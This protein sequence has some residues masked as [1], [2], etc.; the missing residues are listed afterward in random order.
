M[1]EVAKEPDMN[2]A[3][4]IPVIII[5]T[6]LAVAV[7]L[8]GVAFAAS[9]LTTT[10]NTKAVQAATSTTAEVAVY[11][12][13]NPVTGEHHY[14]TDANE[15]KVLKTNYRWT[16]EGVGWF[17]PSKG[18]PVYRLYNK[19][20]GEHL[21]TTDANE[22][23]TL[24]SRYG[25]TSEGIGWY[26]SEK[27]T[28]PVFRLFNRKL[29]AVASHHYTIDGNERKVLASKYGWR[30]EGVAW[31]AAR[32]G[33]S[34]KD[35][36]KKE[37]GKWRWYDEGTLAKSKW[38]STNKNPF[39][40]AAT[41]NQR[42]RA[43]SNGNLQTGF[44]KVGSDSY[45]G[46]PSKGYVLRGKMDYDSDT[47]LVADSTGKLPAGKGW[48]VT[49]TY[50]GHLERYYLESVDSKNSGYY[51]AR[52]GRFSVFGA[53]YFGRF[54]QGYVV[55]GLYNYNGVTYRADNDGK[56]QTGSTMNGI[57]IS[58]WN[59]GIDI[60]RV[61]ADFIVVKATQGNWYTNPYF[62]TWARQILATGKM[63]GI[64]H[65]ADG[66]P[67]ATAEAKHFVNAIKGYEGK[68]VL[69]L[70]W[71]GSAL[72]KGSAYAKTFLDYVYKQ[73]GVRPMIYMSKSVCTRYNWASVA[74]N[75]RLWVAQY[76]Q[77]TPTGYKTNPW[78]DTTTFGAWQQPT[79]FQ[80]TSKGRISGYGGD[81]D[82]NLFYGGKPLWNTIAKKS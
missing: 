31:Y 77:N 50:D 35:G 30:D 44:F 81:L 74:P 9:M 82:L 11:R 69:V 37:S 80:Y 1:Y 78:T 27:K 13:Y 49:A 54:D 8:P 55:R 59:A 39:T 75:Y 43:D 64:Y 23:T 12:L 72:D 2:I 33:Y 19:R 45:Y 53:S 38:I 57:D 26:S 41:G 3:K 14:T 42:Y 28:T 61:D 76:G 16:Y 22:R 47:K 29:R 48:L 51:G 71:E 36:W 60:S 63:L 58:S 5:A 46:I 56:L 20:T 65:F 62:K 70:D 25:W 66:S 17:A 6:A 68:A 10:S 21:Y 7:S 32:K 15:K 79:M 34:V 4:R 18:L 73:T 67:N 40:N 24:V 52:T